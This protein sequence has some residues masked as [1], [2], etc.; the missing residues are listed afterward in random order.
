MHNHPI[1]IGLMFLALIGVG[2]YVFMTPSLR[3]GLPLFATQLQQ[4][5]AYVGEYETGLPAADSGGRKIR[6]SITNDNKVTMTTD[7]LNDKPVIIETGEATAESQG[8]LDITLTKK[9]GVD[10]E[11][12]KHLSFTFKENILTLMDP[13]GLGYGGNGL[14][15]KKTN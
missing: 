13:S 3:N 1:F 9:D 12:V 14:I 5:S 4:Q 10:E 11:I 6:L 7:Y 15:L 2:T 8:V